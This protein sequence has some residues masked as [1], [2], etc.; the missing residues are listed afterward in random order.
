MALPTYSVDDMETA[1]SLMVLFGRRQYD[2][3]YTFTDFGGELE[4]LY[5]AAEKFHEAHQRILA[6]RKK[7]S[8]KE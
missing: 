8:N 3:R 1:K 4:D 7:R 2:G 6:R 5:T